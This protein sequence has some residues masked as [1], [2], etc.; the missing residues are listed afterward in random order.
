[1]ELLY[2]GLAHLLASDAHDPI[3]RPPQL[4]I[5]YETIGRSF[6]RDLSEWLMYNSQAVVRGEDICRG[7]PETPKRRRFF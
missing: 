4:S 5:I 7:R 3:N 2:Y 1:M 6:N